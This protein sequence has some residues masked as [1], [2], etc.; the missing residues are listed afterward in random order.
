MS[1]FQNRLGQDNFIWWVGVVEDRDDPLFLGRCKV[2][3]FGSH[4]EDL[5]LIPTSTL[6]W[7]TP[8]YPVNDSKRFSTPMEGDYVFGF[9]M[10]GLSSQIPTMLGVFP[11]IP[12]GEPKP[13]TGFS[14]LAKV[15]SPLIDQ[16]VS[17]AQ[18][19]LRE[20]SEVSEKQPVVPEVA[21]DLKLIRNGKP[22]TPANAY[23][24]NNTILSWSSDNLAHGCDFRFLINIGDLSV[25]AIDNPITLIEEAIKGAKNKAAAIIRALLSQLLS[26]FRVGLKA[27]TVGLNLDPTGQLSAAFGKVR[28]AVRTI[29]YY[30]RK[31]AEMVGEVALVVALVDELKQI[32]EWIRTLPQQVLALLRDCLATFTNAITA[33]AGQIQALPGQISNSLVGAFENLAESAS[34]T[35]TQAQEAA[36]AANVPNTMITLVTSPDTA[37]ANIITEY[38]TS[39]Y[40]NSN[41]VIA[42]T[43]SASYNIANAST[44]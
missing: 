5:N 17:E 8:L 19:T 42:T 30:S 38:I 29:N 27:I 28:E 34:E 25:G 24:A 22:T 31:L 6:P 12:Q 40:P 33:A 15:Y 21:P 23:T 2:R 9:F 37:N 7:A 36:A 1:E 18:Q 35:V 20:N 3:I 44:P 41:V 10:D 39:E 14:A 16:T 32:V 43:D 11:S 4:T 13:G 26:S